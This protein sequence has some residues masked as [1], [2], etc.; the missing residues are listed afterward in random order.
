MRKVLTSHLI[1]I[2]LQSDWFMKMQQRDFP[3]RDPVTEH[4]VVKLLHY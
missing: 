3:S 1:I 2:D 4:Y